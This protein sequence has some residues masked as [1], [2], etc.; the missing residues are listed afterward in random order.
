MVLPCA[1]ECHVVH[2]SVKKTPH[3]QVITARSKPTRFGSILSEDAR[4]F[5]P[6]RESFR[7]QGSGLLG[8]RAD[9]R[10]LTRMH[11]QIRTVS[12]WCRNKELRYPITIA[13]VTQ[14]KFR[15]RSSASRAK[16]FLKS[17]T[18]LVRSNEICD[19]SDIPHFPVAV[20]IQS[21]ELHCWQR[22]HNIRASSADSGWSVGLL[23]AVTN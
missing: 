9:Q 22:Y 18:L 6:D 17:L 8:K 19:I 14:Y 23:T 5:L 7:R 4:W 1:F 15:V 16:E 2:Y 10:G 13:M 3:S 11:R 20:A 12:F 21:K